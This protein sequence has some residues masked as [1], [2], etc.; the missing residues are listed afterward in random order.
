MRFKVPQNIDMP[1]RI[2]G[3][4]TMLQFIYAVIGGG[5]AYVCYV[6]L[7]SPIGLL[8]AVIVALFT[9][10]MIFVKVNERPFS[11]F[12]LSALKF[13][14]TPR[15]RIW[16]KGGGAPANLNVE[17]YK[18]QKQAGPVVPTKHIS[19]EDIAKIARRI[20]TDKSL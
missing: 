6:S 17:I 20:D 8:L 16:H 15:Q 13:F 2:L 7:P 18:T 11:N 12:L 19:K 14:T 4:L 3:P 9:V 1:D 10:A 5:A